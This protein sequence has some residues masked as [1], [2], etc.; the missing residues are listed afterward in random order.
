MAEETKPQAEPTQGAT[1][2]QVTEK[3]EALPE[4]V[5]KAI[6]SEVDRVRTKY[7]QELKKANDEIEGIKKERMT[8]EEKRR[9][10]L[11]K[12]EREIAEKD[13]LLQQAARK[14]RAREGL[15]A[16]ELEDDLVDMVLGDSDEATSE[17]IKK[18]KAYLIKREQKL[19]DEFLRQTGR[20]VKQA[21]VVDAGLFTEDQVKNFSPEQIARMSEEDNVK[22]L[23]S[24]QVIAGGRR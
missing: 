17:R 23:R 11:D 13:K 8:D 4:N 21:S 10:E 1:E 16:E 20:T 6:Q 7:V 22:L 12:R 2:A 9:F 24:M 15:K 19:K 3:V 18:I 5:R 14:E